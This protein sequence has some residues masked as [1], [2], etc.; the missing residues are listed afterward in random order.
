MRKS[1]TVILATVVIACFQLAAHC[2]GNPPPPPAPHDAGTPADC[3]AA[4]EHLRA[5]K[6]PEGEPTAKGATCED[7]C[8]HAEQSGTITLWPGCMVKLKACPEIESCV[9]GAK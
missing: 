6:C 8:N 5:L 2:D 4:C 7:V 3:T 1:I 9:Y